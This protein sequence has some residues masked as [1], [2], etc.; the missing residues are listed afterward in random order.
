MLGDARPGR[1]VAVGLIP[2]RRTFQA[3]DAW[4]ALDARP[5]TP[6]GAQGSCKTCGRLL[7]QAMGHGPRQRHQSVV[8]ETVRARNIQAR[9][10]PGRCGFNV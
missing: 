4:I 8:V 10:G 7:K 2:P 1:P 3:G 5:C 9:R 6:A